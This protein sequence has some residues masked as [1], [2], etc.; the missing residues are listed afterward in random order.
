MSKSPFKFCANCGEKA[1][2]SKR[3]CN[4]NRCGPHTREDRRAGRKSIWR[5]PTAEEIAEENERLARWEKM[6]EEL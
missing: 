5:E 4:S 1:P 2:R 3:L 6:L